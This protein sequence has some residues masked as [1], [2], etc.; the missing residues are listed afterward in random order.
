MVTAGVK[1]R[2]TYETSGSLFS[3]VGLEERIPPQCPSRKIGQLV[4]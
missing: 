3:D 1:M 2:G 4:K